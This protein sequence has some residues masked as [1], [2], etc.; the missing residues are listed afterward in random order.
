M[1]DLTQVYSRHPYEKSPD[2]KSF[3]LNQVKDLF[4]SNYAF[5]NITNKLP[6]WGSI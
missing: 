4:R 5:P 3:L 2:G 1:K 6:W